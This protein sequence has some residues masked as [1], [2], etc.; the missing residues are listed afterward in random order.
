MS[1]D[2]SVWPIGPAANPANPAPSVTSP[3]QFSIGTSL[4]DGFAFMSTNWAKKN[5]M[6]SSSAFL[7][8]VYASGRALT[9]AIHDSFP[10]GNDVQNLPRICGNCELPARMA[11]NTQ[12]RRPL[13]PAEGGVETQQLQLDLDHQPVLVGHVQPGQVLDPAQ[14]L[15][16]GIG[17][18][19]EGLGGGGDVAAAHQ[20]LLQGVQELGAVALVVGGE[21]AQGVPAGV[22]GAA[23]LG[24]PE[25]VLVGAKVVEANHARARADHGGGGD[26]VLGFLEAGGERGRALAGLGE[27]DRQRMALVQL[28]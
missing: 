20:E 26:R 5:L 15:A 18:H 27:A 10:S 1:G 21:D 4:A 24:H 6:P 11:G 9:V 14:P 8:I 23:V 16:Q 7:R 3:S 28:C 13:S 22:A 12:V 2:A 25:Q 19:V 17:V